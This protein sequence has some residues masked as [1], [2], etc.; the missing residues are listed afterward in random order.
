MNAKRWIALALALASVGVAIWAVI[1]LIVMVAHAIGAFI[2]AL[3]L[4][5]IA[6]ALGWGAMLVA[7]QD[8]FKIITDRIK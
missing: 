8:V 4:L 5:V 2:T 3:V 7:G 6:S 1:L